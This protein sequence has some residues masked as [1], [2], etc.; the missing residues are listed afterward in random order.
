MSM[1]IKI[2]FCIAVFLFPPFI[3]ADQFVSSYIPP[4]RIYYGSEVHHKNNNRVISPNKKWLAFVKTGRY[5]IPK[6]CLFFYDPHYRYGSEIWIINLAN[7]KKRLLVANNF[8]CNH[9]RKVIVDPSD[10]KF[11]PDNKTLYFETSALP[12]SDALHA[13]DVNG[14]NLRYVTNGNEYRVVQNGRFKGDLIVNQHRARFR[15][16]TPLGTYDWDWLF[17]PQGKQ[18]KLYKKED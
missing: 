9:T 7:K 2:I 4:D 1:K 3:F 11:S 10:L 5:P 6:A 17:T 14:K 8:S 18:I 15:G 16:D 12:T 13:I